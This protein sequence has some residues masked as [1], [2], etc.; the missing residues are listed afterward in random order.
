MILPGKLALDVQQ[1]NLWPRDNN[2][3][4]RSIICSKTLQESK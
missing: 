1:I 4:E 2:S 3:D